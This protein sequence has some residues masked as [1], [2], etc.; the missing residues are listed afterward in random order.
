MKIMCQ[1]HYDK[2]VQYAESIG[3]N[4]LRECLERLERRNRNPCCPCQ[5]ELYRDFAPYSYLFKKR[6]PDGR[7]GLVG[8]LVYHGHPDQSHC[9]IDEP[10]HGWMIHT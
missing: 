3:D 6:Y 1:E 2:V 10:F 9:F 7:L 8:G 4:M 5:I